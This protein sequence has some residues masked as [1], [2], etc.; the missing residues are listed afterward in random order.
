MMQ[1]MGLSYLGQKAGQEEQFQ[2]LIVWPSS[3]PIKA[4]PH[5]L[6]LVCNWVGAARKPFLCEV[7]RLATSTPRRRSFNNYDAFNEL[8]DRPA[9]L[10][11]LTVTRLLDGR[12]RYRQSH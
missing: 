7:L 6:D 4:F 9:H 11:V 2:R 3:A 10:A 1:G 8:N 5:S 12:F